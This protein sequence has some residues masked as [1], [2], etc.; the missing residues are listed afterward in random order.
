MKFFRDKVVFGY[1]YGCVGRGVMWGCEVL[2]ES[3][4]VWRAKIAV[5]ERSGIYYV[6]F[7]FS[8]ESRSVGYDG[9]VYGS[10][11]VR[12]VLR[13]SYTKAVFVGE[14]GEIFGAGVVVER[15]LCR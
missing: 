14:A 4:G 15:V 5:I 12:K 11:R 2:F 8:W 13:G 10:N 3:F 6:V 7:V 1:S 9:G